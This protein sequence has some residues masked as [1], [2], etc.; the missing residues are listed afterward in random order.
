MVTLKV[1]ASH[2]LAVNTFLEKKQR[3]RG[4]IDPPHPNLFKIT[5]TKKSPNQ[6]HIRGTLRT[7]SN[8]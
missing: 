1:R 5:Q 8:I 2:S 7:L 4:Q 3:G 6:R